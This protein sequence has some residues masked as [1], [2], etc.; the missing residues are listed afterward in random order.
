VLA[1]PTGC[2]KDRED[3]VVVDM[4]GHQLGGHAACDHRNRHAHWHLQGRPDV[5]AKCARAT[6]LDAALSPR[7][8]SWLA[9]SSPSPC[10]VPMSR[11]PAETGPTI[12]SH[13]ARRAARSIT[14]PWRVRTR[15]L[16]LHVGTGLCRWPGACRFRWS[17]AACPQAGGRPLS[18]TT[19]S[20]GPTTRLEQPV[21]SASTRPPSRRTDT[22]PD[23]PG[24]KP[25][26]CRSALQ[27]A[28]SSRS[29]VSQRAGFKSPRSRKQS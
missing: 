14:R 2:S 16:C 8:I 4:D 29:F 21:A 22:L 17:H 19:R 24:A 1:T 15:A 27:A 9:Y 18:T 12:Q 6:R 13:G 7:L 26:A 25:S 3:L 28:S 10:R 20:S 5:E 23:V 11:S